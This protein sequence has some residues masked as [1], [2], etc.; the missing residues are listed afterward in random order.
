MTHCTQ[1]E[2]GTILRKILCRQSVDPV[3]FVNEHETDVTD[4]RVNVP[5]T[6]REP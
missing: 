5:T 1:G 3:D 4:E 6:Q 2:R